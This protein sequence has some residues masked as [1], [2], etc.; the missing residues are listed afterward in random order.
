VYHGLNRLV[1][2]MHLWRKDAEF[3]AFQRVMIKA[4][5]RHSIR[6]LSHRVFRSEH[7][8]VSP[9]GRLRELREP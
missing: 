4:H 8:C 3:E 7:G 5:R 2:R 9:R 1:G 6:I